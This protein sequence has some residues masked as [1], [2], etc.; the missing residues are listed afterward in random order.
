MFA[1]HDSSPTMML[2]MADTESETLRVNFKKR[3]TGT[4]AERVENMQKFVL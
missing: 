2:L 4:D 1:V 3:G